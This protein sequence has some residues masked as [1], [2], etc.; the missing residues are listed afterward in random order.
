MK[1]SSYLKKHIFVIILYVLLYAMMTGL[2]VALTIL[3]A[4]SVE[5]I[6]L[7]EYENAVKYFSIGLGEP[8]RCIRTQFLNLRCSQSLVNPLNLICGTFLCSF[9]L[10]TAK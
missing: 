7:G 3:L 8:P 4:N 10:I 9:I 5:Y 6:T 2:N 1:I